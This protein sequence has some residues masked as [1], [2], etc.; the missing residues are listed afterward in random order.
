[1][2]E[3]EK[4]IIEING[5]KL[6]VDM[7]HAK[8]IDNYKIGDNVKVLIKGYGESYETHIGIIIGFDEF[9]NLPTINIV[10]CE[11]GYN[12]AEIKLLAFNQKSTNFE[13]CHVQP[14]E[15]ILDK[16][17]ADQYLDYEINKK[18]SE[19]DDLTRKKNYFMSMY[20]KHFEQKD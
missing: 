13:I 17:R 1:M 10:Y 6:E 4:R 2:I 5:I 18:Q 14:Y 9:E 20:G 3:N 16:S 8:R 12:R 15:K 11:I 19:L 7:R